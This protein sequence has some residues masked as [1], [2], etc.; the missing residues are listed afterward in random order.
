MDQSRRRYEGVKDW[1]RLTQP[2][3]PPLVRHTF[4]DRQDAIGECARKAQQPPLENPRLRLIASANPLE[5][6]TDFPK[7]HNAEE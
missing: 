1:G 2:Q 3:A 7:H 6:M 4:V 5:T